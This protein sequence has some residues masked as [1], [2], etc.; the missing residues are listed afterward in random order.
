[1]K[2]SRKDHVSLQDQPVLVQKKSDVRREYCRLK[3]HESILISCFHLPGGTTACSPGYRRRQYCD[4]T[5]RE[6]TS[7]DKS[8]QPAARQT[9]PWRQ[10][11]ALRQAAR[12]VGGKVQPVKKVKVR[13]E[14]T[15]L[16]ATKTWAG[17]TTALPSSMY[18]VR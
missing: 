3:C 9:T 16:G 11:P 5:R 1:M 8:S 14:E 12:P 10:E 4:R 2:G 17:W 13:T 6:A 15:F 7:S 18:S